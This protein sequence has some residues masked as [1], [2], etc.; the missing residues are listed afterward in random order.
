VLSS[1]LANKMT[2]GGLALEKAAGNGGAP[3]AADNGM[4]AKQGSKPLSQGYQN[5]LNDYNGL[6]SAYKIAAD[7][8]GAD[9]SDAVKQT[10]AE[11]ATAKM[12]ELTGPVLG[13][14]ET[15]FGYVN[16]AYPAASSLLGD[17]PDPSDGV[18]VALA[19]EDASFDFR[20]ASYSIDK[21]FPAGMSTCTGPVIGSPIVGL[22]ATQCGKACEATVYPKKCVAFSYYAVDS[23]HLCF[24]LSDIKELMTFGCDDAPKD[25][26]PEMGA[27]PKETCAPSAV[28]MVKM[29][30]VTTGYK[31]DKRKWKKAKRCFGEPA[32]VG[33]GFTAYAMPSLGSSVKLLGTTELE[34]A[35]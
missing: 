18:G 28:C 11:H 3:G 10:E 9:F 14:A 32:K 8:K 17:E 24:M 23:S 35:P 30:E 6:L 13:E 34:A 12:K 33:G 15:M 27:A 29:S 19:A 25:C 26:V 22:S 16:L 31:P 4:L 20:Q 5:G 21:A 7:L 2:E 1:D